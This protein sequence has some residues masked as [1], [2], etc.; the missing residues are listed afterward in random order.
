MSLD[1]VLRKAS[2]IHS[3]ETGMTPRLRSPVA[4]VVYANNRNVGDQLSA[5][6]IGRL[7]GGRVRYLPFERRFDLVEAEID[8]LPRDALIVV[9]GGGLLKASFQTFWDRIGGKLVAERR[10][11]AV[12]GV[13]LCREWP[14]QQL[15]INQEVFR[16]AVLVAVRDEL[17]AEFIDIE[18][19]H[20][21]PCPSHGL[22][23][24]RARGSRP[25]RLLVQATHGDLLDRLDPERG[26]RGEFTSACETLAESLSLKRL[27]VD[28]NVL[29]NRPLAPRFPE[30]VV[31]RSLRRT[32][33]Y[34]AAA[35]DLL[36]RYASA[37]V[38]VTSR[39]HGAI[40]ACALEKPILAFSKDTK[41]STYLEDVR[42]PQAVAELHE[43]ADHSG[44]PL[45]IIDST[46]LD[47][48]ERRNEEVARA[49]IRC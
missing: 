3:S 10:R 37:S 7:L 49:L 20:V 22:V 46:V 23:R 12:W 25:E 17:S 30:R 2:S 45:P 35:D 1:E 48:I 42:L 47:E 9:G 36:A 27:E 26:G 11:F 43:I 18:G 31:G 8:R 5:R 29:V 40:I 24:R 4:A 19:I 6:G 34:F 14:G 16:S 33:G 32:D 13:G 41:L 39:L 44:S 15:V 21:V 28:N 38:V